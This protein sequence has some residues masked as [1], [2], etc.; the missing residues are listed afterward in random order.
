[1][2]LKGCFYSLLP[3]S[4]LGQKESKGHLSHCGFRLLHIYLP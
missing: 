2:V 3:S 4:F 1:M